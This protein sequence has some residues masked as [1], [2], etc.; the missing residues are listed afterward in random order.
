MNIQPLRNRYAAHFLINYGCL[1][2]MTIAIVGVFTFMSYRSLDLYGRHD[3]FC[4]FTAGLVAVA[5]T[6]TLL[7][8]GMLKSPDIRHLVK[9]EFLMRD[10]ISRTVPY[11]LVAMVICVGIFAIQVVTTTNPNELF[12]FGFISLSFYLRNLQT[13]W[14][15]YNN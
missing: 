6:F 1:A 5:T 3:K 2:I 7:T 11:S 13:S 9:Y 14:L 8:S 15:I 12:A 10:V 4:L